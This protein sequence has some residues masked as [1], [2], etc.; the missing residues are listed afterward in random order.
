MKK[1]EKRT[2]TLAQDDEL[3]ERLWTISEQFVNK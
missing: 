2:S 1:K 3:A